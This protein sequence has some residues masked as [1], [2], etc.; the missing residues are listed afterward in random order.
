MN[1]RLF[2]LAAG[3]ILIASF[4]LFPSSQDETSRAAIPNAETATQEPTDIAEASAVDL[5][6]PEEDPATR[7]SVTKTAEPNEDRT[8]REEKPVG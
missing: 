3:L 7:A 6:K 4:F 8:G 1:K 5:A 2:I